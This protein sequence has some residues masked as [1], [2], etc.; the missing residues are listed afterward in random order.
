MPASDAQPHPLA[1]KL[2]PDLQLETRHGRTRVAEFMHAAQGVLL[3]LTADSAVAEKAPDQA[4][5]ITVITAHCLTEPAPAA[6][7]LIRPDGHVAW[8]A[9]PG[10][11]D[12]AAGMNTARAPGSAAHA[13]PD[14]ALASAGPQT[15]GRR[16]ERISQ[17]PSLR[18]IPPQANRNAQNGW[19][20]PQMLRRYGSAPSARARRSHDRVIEDAP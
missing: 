8:A 19:T 11:P 18:G 13:S 20:S 3:D 7:L 4:G 5:L 2:A 9:G 6:A 10:T 14:T 16:A 15:P 12:P 17:P 1:G